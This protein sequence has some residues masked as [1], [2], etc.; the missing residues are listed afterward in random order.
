MTPAAQFR[1]PD[2]TPAQFIGIGT[3]LVNTALAFGIHLSA[4]QTKVVLGDIAL[5]GALMFGD[6][7]VRHGRATGNANRH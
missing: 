7:V 2:L 1:T 4:V 6:A 3:A 5:A